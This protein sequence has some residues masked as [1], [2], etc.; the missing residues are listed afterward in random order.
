MI[1]NETEPIFKKGE[2]RLKE[3]EQISNYFRSRF[4]PTSKDS[5]YLSYGQSRQSSPQKIQQAETL[6]HTL[7]NNY[8]VVSPSLSK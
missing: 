5:I 8:K 3:F 7:K 6:I 1:F 4:V 2:N